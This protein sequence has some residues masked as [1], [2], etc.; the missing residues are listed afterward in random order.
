MSSKHTIGLHLRVKD[1]L[2]NVVAEANEFGLSTFQFFLIRQKAT[3]HI[4]LNAKDK[5]AF[6]AA[7]P[8][9]GPLFVHSSYW[10]NP[11]TCNKETFAFSKMLLKKELRMAATL[12]L[13][14]LVLHAGSARGYLSSPS[15]PQSKKAG[16]ATL[17]KMLNS[18]LK[19]E[20]QVKILLENSAHGKKTIG[21]DLEDFVLLKNE[22]DFPERI[23]FCFDT[24]HAF[25]YGYNLEP[26]DELVNIIDRTM[27]LENLKVI[28]FND[29]L[30]TH[31]SMQ[32]RHAF[33][34]QGTIGKEVLQKVLSHPKLAPI[35]KIIEGPVTSKNTTKTVLDEVL[36]W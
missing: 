33:P 8:N 7:R 23:G 14:Y 29:T 6:L 32:D 25:S 36:R 12:E 31:G 17:A 28:H 4:T 2:A 22:L 26:V 19:Q 9:F 16:I 30:D 20:R 5:E 18:L 35:P 13:D 3:T 27:G 34:G 24:A 15:D 11:A 10:I 1:T 21:N